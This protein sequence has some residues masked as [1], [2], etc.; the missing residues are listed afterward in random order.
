[1][2]AIDNILTR[3]SPLELSPPV[4][5]EKQMELVYKAAFRAPDHALLKPSRFIQLTD[6]GIDKLSEI[7]FNYG[8]NNIENISDE[9]LSKFKNAPYR[10][11]MIIVL[12]SSITNH[13]SVP[14]HEQ[15]F[16]TAASA[17]NI[18]L[19]LHAIGFAGIWRTGVFAMNT[20]IEKSLGLKINQ[21]IIGYLY[22]GTPTGKSKKISETNIRKFVTKIE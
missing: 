15:M 1:M 13:Q 3:N 8:K 6:K 17:Q 12:V 16:S 11:P 9:K 4:P 5:N 14:E 21:K 22:V 19:A 18:L 2:K 7:F 10:A 20:Y